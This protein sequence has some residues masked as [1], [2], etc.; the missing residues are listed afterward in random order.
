MTTRTEISELANAMID[1]YW[2]LC[3]P[4]QA[5]ANALAEYTHLMNLNIPFLYGEDVISQEAFLN[6]LNEMMAWFLA[7]AADWKE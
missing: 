6:A 1:N 7:N 3:S 2:V 4:T 5:V